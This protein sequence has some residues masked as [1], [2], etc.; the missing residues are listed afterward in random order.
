LYHRAQ[1]AEA[2]KSQA[3]SQA[4]AQLI[5]TNTYLLSLPSSAFKNDAIQ[6]TQS[7]MLATI[8][9]IGVSPVLPSSAL[10]NSI[11]VSP[12][13]PSS[14]LPNLPREPAG[15][16]AV[17]EDEVQCQICQEMVSRHATAT[18][19][20]CSHT[21]HHACIQQW[22]QRRRANPTCPVCRYSLIENDICHICREE[23]L[24]TDT[25]AMTPCSHT[26]HHACISRWVQGNTTC[27][28]CTF[29]I[30]GDFI[31]AINDFVDPDER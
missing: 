12:V 22:L 29:D 9:S 15:P 23:L 28:E 25:T 14:A 13:L 20:P 3:T 1:K 27:P 26:F 18:T 7:A 5:S 2:A 19:T 10:P 11:G 30:A 24:R 4:L 21:F 16:P 6:A 17:V 8:Q 31:N